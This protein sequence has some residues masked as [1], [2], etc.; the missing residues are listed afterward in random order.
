MTKKEY[1]QKN[2]L[3]KFIYLLIRPW[4]WLKLFSIL[5]LKFNQKLERPIINFFYSKKS[6]TTKEAVKKITGQGGNVSIYDKFSEEIK[7]A[8]DR[9]KKGPV[10]L[11][12]W[13]E[14][15]LIYQL[16]EYLKA[17]RVIETGVSYGG[18]SLAFLL[19]L[20]NRPGSLLISTDLLSDEQEADY[21]GKAVPEYLNNQWKFIKKADEESLPEALEILPEIDICHYDSDK[22]YNGRMFAYPK[23][24]QALRPGGIFISDDIGDNLAFRKFA[25]QIEVKP[26]FVKRGYGHV[27]VLV[28][29][30][31]GKLKKKD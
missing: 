2:L 3:G 17:T 15:D 4:L 27:G 9:V 25:K 10:P 18:S 21:I 13:A 24:W 16:T 19:S 11:T 5:R 1:Q 20:K 14:L 7:E 26:I 12:S 30:K 22:S 29:D 23:L 28:K 6:I 31:N 8:K